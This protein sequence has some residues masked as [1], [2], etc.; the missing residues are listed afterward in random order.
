MQDTRLVEKRLKYD[1]A[2]CTALSWG[3]Q[4]KLFLSLF[5]GSSER[6]QVQL[7]RIEF[8][9]KVAV[10]KDIANGMLLSEWSNFIF[11]YLFLLLQPDVASGSQNKE[12]QELT[13]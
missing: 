3:S 6:Y 8:F 11:I 2:S 9:I 12:S 4:P 5:L 13:A 7:P 10:K 1:V